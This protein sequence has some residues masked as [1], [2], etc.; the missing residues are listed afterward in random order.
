MLDGHA[1]PGSCC[2]TP[3]DKMGAALFLG[4]KTGLCTEKSALKNV[5][6]NLTDLG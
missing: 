4:Q 3:E 2:S 5:P 6:D 1:E